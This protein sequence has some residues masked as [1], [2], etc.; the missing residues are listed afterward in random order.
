MPRTWRL[1][2]LLVATAALGACGI[3]QQT[4]HEVQSSNLSLGATDL[5]TGGVGFLTPAAA[6]GREA[7]KQALAQAFARALGD[8][9][10]GV[11]IVPL[12]SILSDVNAADLDQ[13]YKSMYRDYLET[14]IL[15]GSVLK[16]VGEVGG[17]RYLVQLSLADFQQLS[18]SRLSF[19][20]LRLMDTKQ[21][22]LRVFLQVWDSHTGAVAWE[23]GG[24]LNYAYDSATENPAPLVTVASRAA[25]RLLRELPGSR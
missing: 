15:E 12:P 14:G 2:C 24:E 11:K 19:F 20:G 9:R 7:D 17:V 3:G 21:A 16:R 25:E 8:A 13:D 6:T 23:G 18:R 1:L 5:E 10:P 4:R 22:N